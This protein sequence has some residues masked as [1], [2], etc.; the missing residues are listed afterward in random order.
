MEGICRDILRFHTSFLDQ[1]TLS[2]IRHLRTY[3]SANGPDH[4]T[5]DLLGLLR[6]PALEESVRTAKYTLVDFAQHEQRFH[7][8]RMSHPVF[9][10]HD[11]SII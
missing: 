4:Y 5:K 10:L 1:L 8:D 6:K 9:T 7:E 11:P 2:R 3:Q